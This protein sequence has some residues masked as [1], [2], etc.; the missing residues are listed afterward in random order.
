MLSA[1]ARRAGHGADARPAGDGT[2]NGLRG[3]RDR[4]AL[5]GGELSA[6]PGPRGGFAVRVRL[7]LVP[8]PAE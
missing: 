7:P 1:G 5:L 6:A 3:M 8:E 4:V 2:G